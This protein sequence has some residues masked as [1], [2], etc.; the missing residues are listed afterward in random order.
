MQTHIQKDHNNF[1][2]IHCKVFLF[3]VSDST[4]SKGQKSKAPLKSILDIENDL[5]ASFGGS[6]S[7][8]STR[9]GRSHNLA[10]PT[11]YERTSRSSSPTQKTSPG[12]LSPLR[13]S[14]PH[15]HLSTLSAGPSPLNQIAFSYPTSPISDD[16]MDVD[17]DDTSLHGDEILDDD[18]VFA[19]GSLA[20]IPLRHLQTMP[21]IQLI[22]CT[23]CLVG[24]PSSSAVS[25]ALEHKINLTKAEKYNIKEIINSGHFA[26]Q[27]SDVTPPAYPCPPIKGIKVQDG[28]ICNLCNYCCLSNNTMMTHF[29]NNHKGTSGHSK[30]NSEHALVQSF[31]IK[32]PKY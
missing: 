26:K 8:G 4:P 19:K 1:K 14:S 31:F 25:H 30:D 21:A 22:A 17:E 3:P 6:T 2:K 18:E 15:L 11:P 23:L 10:R 7:V 16:K 9:R 28:F 20:I 32:H 27:S 5:A 24:V 12:S 13:I 29:G